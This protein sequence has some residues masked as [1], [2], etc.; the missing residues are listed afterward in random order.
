MILNAVPIFCIFFCLSSLNL[1]TGQE[2][3]DQETFP[4]NQ[5]FSKCFG[6][7]ASRVCRNFENDDPIVFG[8]DKNFL[9]RKE[10]F[11]T[12]SPWKSSMYMTWIAQ[13]IISEILHF[14]V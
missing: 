3:I 2:S 5:P 6:S 11:L 4:A 14:P 8:C 12:S 7:E 10:I 9:K 13:I 1:V